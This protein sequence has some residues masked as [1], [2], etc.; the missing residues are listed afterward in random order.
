[1]ND[2]DRLELRLIE[3][4]NIRQIVPLLHQRNVALSL[5]LLS[6]RV[7]EMTAQGFQCLGAYRDGQLIAIAGFWV[8]TRYHTGKL[9]E[10][11][12]VFVDT[13][14]RSDGIGEKMVMWICDFGRRQ[15]CL[16]SELHCYV[17]NAG[18][19]KFWLNRGYKIIAFHFGKDI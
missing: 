15:G 17:D 2:N 9:I 12:G 3:A 10:P 14:H 7:T 5:E 18:A 6:E 16:E 19:H 8:R 4:K 11:D 13:E 1:L